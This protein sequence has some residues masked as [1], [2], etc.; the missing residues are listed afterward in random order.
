MSEFQSR[1]LQ[2]EA[3]SLQERLGILV[4]QTSTLLQEIQNQSGRDKGALSEGRGMDG[5]GAQ[6]MLRRNQFQ[7]LDRRMEALLEKLKDAQTGQ[8]SVNITRILIQQMRAQ[9]GI[10]LESLKGVS[11]ELQLW[12]QATVTDSVAQKMSMLERLKKGLEASK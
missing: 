7:E 12:E 4:N 3:V 6:L 10:E 5:Y 9:I 2:E 11:E 1:I 8:E